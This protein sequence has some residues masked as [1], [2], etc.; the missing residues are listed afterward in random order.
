V[1]DVLIF[2]SM[3]VHKGVPNRGRTLRMSMDV[4]Y[5]LA[6]DSFNPDNAQA[7]GQPLSWDEIY[8]GWRSDSLQY[9]WRRMNLTHSAF[10][11]TWFAKRDDRAFELGERGDRRAR[12]VLQ[13]IVARDADA[14]KRARAQ[15]L[16]DAMD[17]AA[18]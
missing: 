8:A 11:P 14:A 9:Y 16:L 10:D 18:S 13:R 1:G 12:S 17:T 6:G 15:A 5:Q 7:D 4:R 3:L 2:H